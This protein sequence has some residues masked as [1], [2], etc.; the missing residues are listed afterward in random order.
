MAENSAIEWTDHTFNPWVGCSR[1]SPGCRFCYAD[2]DVSRWQPDNTLWRR[3]G[4]RRVTS[5]AYWRKPLKWNRDAERAGVPVKVFAA[6]LADVFEDHP[7]VPEP[8]AR[9]F[10]LIDRTPWLTWQLLTKRPGNVA[11]MVPWGA[12]WPRNVWLGTSVED[13]RRADERLP[14]L[15]AVPAEVRWVSA[16][17]L[18]DALDL[19]A[20]LLPGSAR[21]R[22]HRMRGWQDTGRPVSEGQGIDWVVAGGESGADARPAHPDWFRSIRDQC[23][24]AGVPFLFKQW[25]EWTPVRP[26]HWFGQAPAQ[27][28]A[29]TRAFRPDGTA[30]RPAEPDTLFEPAMQTVYRA[31]KKTAGRELDGCTWDQYPI[32]AAPATA[33]AT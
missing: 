23:A 26:D 31:G 3:G 28:A 21:R 32:P 19:T 17:P 25:G 14:D 18:L 29:R 15:A 10:D 4:E 2:R 6:S 33:P 12:S 16:E 9:L 20:V 22:A 5:V 8:R 11:G 30:Y 27:L 7:A 24:A 1:V 13:Q